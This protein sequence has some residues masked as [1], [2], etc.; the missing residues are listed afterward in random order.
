MTIKEF[1]QSP[2]LVEQWGAVLQSPLARIV[3]EMMRRNH[4]SLRIINSDINPT[5]AATKLGHITGYAE[6]EATL[7]L[8]STHEKQTDTE[9]AQYDPDEG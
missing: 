4:P 8:L 3:L 1:R 6:Y 7:E 9:E 5:F 2:D